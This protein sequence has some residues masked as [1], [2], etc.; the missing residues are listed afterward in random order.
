MPGVDAAL[1][2]VGGFPDTKFSISRIAFCVLLSRICRD[3][4][5]LEAAYDS[6]VRM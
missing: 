3:F 5:I 6:L 4:S 2:A 1:L